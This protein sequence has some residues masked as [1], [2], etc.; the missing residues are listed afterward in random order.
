MNAT[1][2]NALLN[3]G[4]IVWLSGV[5]LPAWQET[6]DGPDS[7]TFQVRYLGHPEGR[8]AYFTFTEV[9]EGPGPMPE[10]TL[11]AGSFAL[12]V[13]KVWRPCRICRETLVP[14]GTDRPL[15]GLA[16]QECEDDAVDDYHRHRAEGELAYLERPTS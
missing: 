12:G 2:M 11:A 5:P 13:W 7:P 16:C 15:C 3:V 14:L 9:S 1:K 4:D 6:G 10:F 8:P